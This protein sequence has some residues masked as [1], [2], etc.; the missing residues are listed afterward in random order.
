MNSQLIFQIIGYVASVLIGISMM[1]KSVRRLRVFNGIGAFVFVIYG[2]LIKAY[3]VAILNALV[4]IIDTYYFTKMLK[5]KDFFTVMEVD[6]DSTYLKFFLDFNKTVIQTFFPKFKYAPKPGDLIFFILRDTI[7]AGLVIVRPE[8][9]TGHVLLDYALKNYRDFKIGSFIFDDNSDVLLDRG[10]TDL[11]TKGEDP[12]HTK[13]L[14][15]M[16]FKQGEDGLFRRKLNPH[17][18]QDQDI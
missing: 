4:V 7:P 10:I 1:M 16:N 15:Q 18:I 5:R 8:K 13:Y 2:I 14:R 17:F 3:P 12:I 11:V 9:H 6:P